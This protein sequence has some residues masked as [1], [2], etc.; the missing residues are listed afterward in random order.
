LDR[1]HAPQEAFMRLP[2]LCLLSCFALPV[3][4]QIYKYTDANGNPAYS[5]QPPQGVKAQPV[6]LPPLNSIEAPK[7]PA[8]AA[9]SQ[10]PIN[11]PDQ[12][13]YAQLAL[14]DVPTDEAL[15]ANGGSFTVG[16]QM[17]P[18]LGADDL[19]QL[20]L[21]GQPYGQPSNVPRLQ[22]VDIDRGEHSL[23]VQVLRGDT[24]IQQS[25]TLT[26]TVQRVSL[27]SPARP[28]RP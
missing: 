15:R 23:A 1:L 3:A 13:P 7:R 14:T 28:S 27:N 22:L 11:A 4:A 19:L 16:V 9:P 12:P 26:F 5:N 10:I 8:P 6:E 17:G 18:R 20:I 2:L 24:A 21:D 25:A